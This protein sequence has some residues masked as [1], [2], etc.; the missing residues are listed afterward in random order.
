KNQGARRPCSLSE[1]VSVTASRSRIMVKHNERKA[2]GFDSTKALQRRLRAV[3]SM[4][5]NFS[6]KK[7]RHVSERH[8]RGVNPV[9]LAAL[10]AGVDYGI[11]V[12]R[13]D[14]PL[15]FSSVEK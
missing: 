12:D 7:P 14:Q 15:G 3:I 5:S 13:R 9:C 6:N 11:K 4:H 10:M 2:R 8:L 1:L